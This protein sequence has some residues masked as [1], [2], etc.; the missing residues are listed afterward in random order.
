MYVSQTQDEY[1]DKSHWYNVLDTFYFLIELT[2]MVHMFSIISAIV[3]ALPT[4]IKITKI[5]ETTRS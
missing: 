3:Y 1:N 5:Q 4:R 2:H